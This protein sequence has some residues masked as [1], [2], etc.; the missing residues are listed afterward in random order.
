MLPSQDIP[1]K[2]V[3][4]IVYDE[5]TYW[6]GEVVVTWE[7]VP[8]FERRW[9]SNDFAGLKHRFSTYLK[10]VDAVE[11]LLNAMAGLEPAVNTMV[12]E[13]R[14][15]TPSPEVLPVTCD[16]RGLWALVRREI[17]CMFFKQVAPTR[18]VKLATTMITP[19]ATSFQVLDAFLSAA[20]SGSCWRVSEF[21]QHLDQAYFA[22]MQSSAIIALPAANTKEALE[23][24]ENLVAAAA[25]LCFTVSYHGWRFWRSRY[26]RKG[27]RV[28]GR[29]WDD[30]AKR[31]CVLG[32]G[33]FWDELVV[34]IN[35]RS[36]PGLRQWCRSRVR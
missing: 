27:L 10:F 20:I 30:F 36:E 28:I 29:V 34:Y 7:G 16:K 26:A 22:L 2:E 31:G 4:A 32:P 21:V 11:T 5:S 35:R 23:L 8:S 25:Q 3:L 33:P 15:D 19:A 6:R 14:A 9:S 17:S 13:L 24:M 1:P 18:V 12:V